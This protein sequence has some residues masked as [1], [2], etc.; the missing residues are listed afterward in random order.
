MNLTSIVTN[1]SSY[2]IILGWMLILS[3]YYQH[4]LTPS[5]AIAIVTLLAYTIKQFPIGGD[6]STK[7]ALPCSSGSMCYLVGN[8]TGCFHPCSGLTMPITVDNATYNIP[9]PMYTTENSA[10]PFSAF[11]F[12]NDTHYNESAILNNGFKRVNY[13]TGSDGTTS[14]VSVELESSNFSLSSDG[15]AQLSTGEIALQCPGQY[16]TG[17]N[18][19]TYMLYNLSGDD[20]KINC[21]PIAARVGNRQGDTYQFDTDFLTETDQCTAPIKSSN[22]SFEFVNYPGCNNPSDNND[23]QCNGFDQP[24]CPKVTN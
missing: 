3:Y 11:A 2:V 7:Q 21:V 23:P 17:A 14:C 20:T 16:G 8:D 6:A 24:S 1:F 9:W 22:N 10:Y 4:G 5:S 19:L 18:N 12:K 13:G 15:C